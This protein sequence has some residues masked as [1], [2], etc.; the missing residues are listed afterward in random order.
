MLEG[1]SYQVSVQISETRGKRGSE[2]MRERIM[3]EVLSVNAGH[4]TFNTPRSSPRTPVVDQPL[5]VNVLQV[6]FEIPLLTSRSW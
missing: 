1:C 2:S 4:L 3:L 5:L 6:T